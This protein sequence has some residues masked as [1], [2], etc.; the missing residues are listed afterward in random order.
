MIVLARTPS[1]IATRV[2]GGRTS[3]AVRRSSMGLR[4]LGISCA[5]PRARRAAYGT[6]FR[7]YRKPLALKGKLRM[8]LGVSIGYWGLG[9][10]AEQQSE[11]VREA[12][13]L[14]YDS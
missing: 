8:K 4:V 7:P 12:E 9:L 2:C 14:G 1:S 11:I 13:E 5:L 10:T 6:P 3:I